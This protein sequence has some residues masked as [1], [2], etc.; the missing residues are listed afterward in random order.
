MLNL[1]YAFFLG[2]LSVASFLYAGG[3]IP[4]YKKGSDVS[5][6]SDS[7]MR[8]IFAICGVSTAILFVIY[9]LQY[10]GMW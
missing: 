3:L 9:L 2:A 4:W 8:L 1:V 7:K 5:R 10:L 6:I